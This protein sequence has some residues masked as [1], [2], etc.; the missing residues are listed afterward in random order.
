LPGVIENS[1]AAGID[2]VNSNQDSLPI[3]VARALSQLSNAKFD[4]ANN[5]NALCNMVRSNMSSLVVELGHDPALIFG[6]NKEYYDPGMWRK[7]VAAPQPLGYE[8]RNPSQI[9]LETKHIELYECDKIYDQIQTFH[10]KAD[11]LRQYGVNDLTEIIKNL[12]RQLSAEE[13][14]PLHNYP[15]MLLWLK[16]QLE[17]E[18]KSTCNGYCFAPNTLPKDTQNGFAPTYRYDFNLPI[19]EQHKSS[20]GIALAY[21]GNDLE[22][23]LQASDMTKE[24]I[25]FELSQGFE[26]VNGVHKAYY[27]DAISEKRRELVAQGL[28]SYADSTLMPIEVLNRGSDGRKYSVWLDDIVV[29]HNK[30]TLNAYIVIE[31]PKS[32]QKIVFKGENLEFSPKGLKI[33]PAKLFLINEVR[34]RMSNS[35]ELVLPQNQSYVSFNC[36]GY[37]GMGIKGR[38]EICRE[39]VIPLDRVQYT[40][41]PEPARVSGD[42]SI[43]IPTFDELYAEILVTPFAIKGI[44]DMAWIIDTVAI[45]FS[46]VQSPTNQPPPGYNSPFATNAAFSPLWQGVYIKTLAV[47]L[48]EGFTGQGNPPATIGVQKVVIDHSGVS[49]QIFATPVLSIDQGNAGGWAFSIDTFQLTVLSNIPSQ[50]GFSGLVNIP[51]FSSPGSNLDSKP[52]KPDC[53]PYTASIEPGINGSA[54]FRFMVHPRE[55]MQIDM[56]RAG[57]VVIHP[58]SKI[59]MNYEN[60]QFTTLANLSGFIKIDKPGGSGLQLNIPKIDF[61]N[62]QVSNQAPY[63]SPGTWHMA[64][65][66]GVDFGGFGIQLTN[67][68]MVQIDNLPALH[69]DARIKIGDAPTYIDA[70]GGI[71]LVGTLKDIDGRQR[72]VYKDFDVNRILVKAQFPGVKN[73]EGVLDFYKNNPN[74]GTGWRGAIKMHITGLAEVSA[75]AQFGKVSS[76]NGS[77]KYFMV[78]A[79]L[80]MNGAGITIAPGISIYGLGGGVYKNMSRPTN[81]LPLPQCSGNNTSS[82]IPATIGTSLSGVTYTP[83]NTGKVGIKVTVAIKA[84]KETAFNANAT[85]EVLFNSGASGI[86]NIWLYGNARFMDIPKSNASPT[87]QVPL[88]TKIGADL[89]ISYDFASSTLHGNLNV[90]VDVPGV[91]RGAGTANRFTNAEIHISPDIWYIHIGKPSNPQGL[92]LSIPGLGDLLQ[93]KSYLQI[94]KQLDPMPEVPA[95]IRELAGGSSLN[96]NGRNGLI[97]GEGFAFG[98]SISTPDKN[99]DKGIIFAHFKAIMGFDV[100]VRDFGNTVICSQTNSPIGINGW[101]ASGQIYAGVFG[102][103]GLKVKIFGKRR[104]FHAFKIEAA[105]VLQAS[106]PNPFWARG[107]VS[108]SYEILNGLVKGQCKLEFELG[109]KCDVIGEPENVELNVIQSIMPET[110]TSGIAVDVKP[111]VIFAFPIE[112]NFNLPIDE[113]TSV[114]YKIKLVSAKMYYQNFEIGCEKIWNSS[115]DRLVLNPNWILP[116]NSDIRVRVEVKID[117]AGQIVDNQFKEVTFKTGAGLKLIPTTNVAGSYPFDGQYNFYQDEIPNKQGYIKLFKNQPDLFWDNNYTFAVRFSSSNGDCQEISFKGDD[118]NSLNQTLKFDY[119]EGFFQSNNVYRLQFVRYK[120]GIRPVG[121]LTTAA[122]TSQTG[123]KFVAASPCRDLLSGYDNI[124]YTAYFRVSEYKTFNE[125]ITKWKEGKTDISYNN[126]VRVLKAEHPDFEPFDSKETGNSVVSM[127]ADFAS[128]NWYQNAPGKMYDFMG[129][130]EA[131]N[132]NIKFDEPRP[133]GAIPNKAV[134]FRNDDPNTGKKIT[135]AEWQLGNISTHTVVHLENKVPKMYEADY[136]M[137]RQ[138]ANIYLQEK[139]LYPL[140][141]A[142]Q[143]YN[144]NGQNGQLP[145]GAP[146]VISQTVNGISIDGVCTDNCSNLVVRNVLKMA[147]CSSN[148]PDLPYGDY[149]IYIDYR[150]PGYNCNEIAPTTNSAGIVIKMKK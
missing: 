41:L 122:N 47:R 15:D 68:G 22:T 32:G 48:P 136:L 133:F 61:E 74:Y 50:A 147:R 120:K 11:S 95:A 79:L 55:G 142:V 26:Y 9:S 62:V 125:K 10:L 7:F 44:E 6:P 112:K 123:N 53:Y 12:L 118:Y 4:E 59:E 81:S 84:T 52:T 29:R 129:E 102:D 28:F 31:L 51:I 148:F 46:D 141:N 63:F 40:P 116:G 121:N 124:L 20:K 103:L 131:I 96:I 78:D 107:A 85:F 18:V 56:W 145:A 127:R 2:L 39:H 86:S 60:R 75:V 57:E 83:E 13:A 77:F 58:S 149:S 49:G 110:N 117:S 146:C 43:F 130:T 114:N 27:Y 101:Y 106:L 115:L 92:I 45:D 71:S 97:T 128:T 144:Q 16:I 88:D 24:D 99:F 8:T 138:Y 98:M 94:G 66:I 30:A 134:A 34:V 135:N 143:Q 89:D 109:E 87:K 140:Y 139:I 150:L 35:T 69:F 3:W 90:Y 25:I 33:N 14:S 108:G 76:D 38:V 54:H 70:A 65:G 67:V 100:A 111:E 119:P 23:L 91:L 137:F 1:T 104:E 73:L 113:S 132:N 105:A 93:V 64:G 82:P 72:W 17:K 5:Q 36:E 126:S 19:N 80:C 37:A 21:N 42:F